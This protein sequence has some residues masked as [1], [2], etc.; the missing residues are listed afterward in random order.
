MRHLGLFYKREQFNVI[1]QGMGSAASVHTRKT[2][3][4]KERKE[5][6]RQEGREEGRKEGR[7]TVSFANISC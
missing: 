1:W 5:A 3:G 2:V 7:K 4:K 6:G